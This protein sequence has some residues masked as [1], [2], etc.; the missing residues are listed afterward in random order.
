MI[1]RAKERVAHAGSGEWILGRGWDQNRWPQK[2]F[3]TTPQLDAAISDHPVWLKRVDG[4]AGLANTAAIRAAG[5]TAQT[6]DPDGG[7]I[8]RDA[9]GNPTGVFLDGA[10]SL[11]E[12]KIPPPS[13]ALRKKRVLAAAREIAKNGLTEMHDAGAEDDTIRAI[14]ELID[15][16][17]FPIRVYVMLSDE[18]RLVDKYLAAGPLRITAAS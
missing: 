7:R 13:F 16:G 18:Q 6:P 10:M 5:V 14:K 8:M 1:A 3:P 11:I 2:D 17:S 12:A 4:H 15:E 9:A